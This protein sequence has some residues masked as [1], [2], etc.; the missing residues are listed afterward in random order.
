MGDKITGSGGCLC[1]KIHYE[2][3]GGLRPISACH[4]RQ[5]Q[6]TSGNYVTATSCKKSEITIY[7]EENL[8]WYQSSSQAERGFCKNCGGN[9][10]WRKHKKD[11]ISIMAGTLDL[12]TGLKISK[13]IFVK[14]KSDYYQLNDGIEQFD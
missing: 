1:G 12:P 14:D 7:G 6:K 2:I 10:F 11:N 13:H 8:K 9:L 5:C 3:C 4:C